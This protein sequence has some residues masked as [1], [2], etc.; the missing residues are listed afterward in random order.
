VFS[1]SSFQIDPVTQVVDN[2]C[3]PVQEPSSTTDHIKITKLMN[4]SCASLIVPTAAGVHLQKG[5][6]IE[7]GS[8]VSVVVRQTYT[9]SESYRAIPDSKLG[10]EYV[11]GTYC[12]NGGSCQFAV[13]ATQ[14]RTSVNIILPNSA[15]ST[16]TCVSGQPLNGQSQG[17]DFV[18]TLNELDVF[19]LENA[20]DLSGTRIVANNPIS[21]IVG[22]RDIPYPNGNVGMMVEQI[23][24]I[25]K[26]GTE[27]MIGPGPKNDAGD[28]IKIVTNTANTE[29]YIQGF[30]EFIIPKG[31]SAIERRIDW[32]MNSIVRTSYPVMILQVVSISLY[33][34]T[35]GTIQGTPSMVVVP[36]KSQR[37]VVQT[38]L[39]VSCVATASYAYVVAGTNDRTVSFGCAPSLQPLFPMTSEVKWCASATTNGMFTVAHTATFNAYAYCDPGELF[40]VNVEWTDHTGVQTFTCLN[41]CFNFLRV[42]NLFRSGI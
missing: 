32:G 4:A 37:K 39:Y 20:N 27:F 5:I 22:G 16:V 30:S 29:V 34:T 1:A 24:P 14:D 18:V 17:S 13:I 3:I 8:D 11:V 42:V 10:T 19:Y 31:A 41:Y 12:S 2:N 40:L 35:A 23:P 21:V 7:A 15:A 6:K 28:I 25:S 36:S 33:T 38:D 9:D 26:W